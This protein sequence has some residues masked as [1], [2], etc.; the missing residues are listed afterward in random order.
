LLAFI[1]F[2]TV[3]L[4]DTHAHDSLDDSLCPLNV[5]K[6]DGDEFWHPA[7]LF[8]SLSLVAS[9][10][11]SARYTAKENSRLK[12]SAAAAASNVKEE[13]ATSKQVAAELAAA[14][15]A[16]GMAASAAVPFVRGSMATYW[17]ALR[18]VITPP[19]VRSSRH[20][21]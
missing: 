4:N 5:K 19:E 8:R 18:G 12:S 7:E 17:K 1:Y 16:G 2:K 13:E 11:R 21:R 15:R 9:V 10:A 6:V 3:F 20:Q 14:E